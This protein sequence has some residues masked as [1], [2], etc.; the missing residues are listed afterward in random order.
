MLNAL[1]KKKLNMCKKNSMTISNEQ[2]R[3][4][5]IQKIQL[6]QSQRT[7]LLARIKQRQQQGWEIAKNG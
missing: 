5:I 2:K 6:V 7:K 4:D 1:M 3:A